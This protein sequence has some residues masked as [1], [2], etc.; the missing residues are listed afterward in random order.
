MMM[1]FFLSSERRRRAKGNQAPREHEDRFLGWMNRMNPAKGINICTPEHQE[2]TQQLDPSRPRGIGRNKP[3][4][5][6]HVSEKMSNPPKKQSFSSTLPSYPRSFIT[7]SIDDL[8]LH[9][10]V[11]HHSRFEGNSISHKLLFSPTFLKTA[12]I[13]IFDGF[14]NRPSDASI[15]MKHFALSYDGWDNP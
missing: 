3:Q 4:L 1:K 11:P 9:I 2:E 10:Y 15:D 13:L 12:M 5:K 7:N 8:T 14:Y 6:Q